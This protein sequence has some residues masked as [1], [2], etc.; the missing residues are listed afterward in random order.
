ML[1]TKRSKHL[2]RAVDHYLD[3]V[4]D[5]GDFEHET[6]VD[7]MLYLLTEYLDKPDEVLKT[8]TDAYNELDKQ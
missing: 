7:F 2:E 3:V 1:Q 6:L 5:V 8:L 4:D